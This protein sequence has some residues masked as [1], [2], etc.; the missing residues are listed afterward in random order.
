M[1][2]VITIASDEQ[3]TPEVLKA[4]DKLVVVD[5][6]ATWCGPCKQVAPV[7][8]MLS[9]KFTNIVFLKVDVDVCKETSEKFRIEAMPT[10]CF[11]RSQKVLGQVKGA[12]PQQLMAKIDELTKGAQGEASGSGG[13]EE[14]VPGYGD[15]KQFIL[16]TGCNCLNESDENTHKNVF[17]D[18]AKY[19]E[20][21]CD[22]QLMLTITFNQQVK[23][24]SLKIRGPS[25]GSA[26]K[27]I[28]IFA[29][30]PNEVDFDSGERM[31]AVQKLELTP[32]EASGEKVISLR[33]VKFQNV[34]NLVVFVV[35]NQGGEET[36]KVEYIK[37]IG[38][39]CNA[40]NM[41]EFKRVSGKAGESHM[42]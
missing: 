8:E 14:E 36:T 18:D 32:E 34:S 26:P 28:K 3:F 6:H 30:Q 23:V 35:D 4:A 5:F 1:S 42:G 33:F 7:Y 13:A 10:F 24:H 41:G 19:L 40:T 9:N 15:L 27:T 20:S 38:V 16:D 17:T 37:V 29:N 12:D 31:E 2:R 39:P 21:D 11:I 22:E 25:D